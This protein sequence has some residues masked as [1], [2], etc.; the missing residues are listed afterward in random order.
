M[1]NIMNVKTIVMTT[2]LSAVLLAGCEN[3]GKKETKA[4]TG[5][6]EKTTTV[7][8]AADDNASAE[9][10]ATEKETQEAKS[11]NDKKEEKSD[12]QNKGSESETF[13]ITEDN[14]LGAWEYKVGSEYTGMILEEGQLARFL[15]T[16]GTTME[17][18]WN[19][20]DGILKVRLRGGMESFNL[21]QDKLIATDGSREYLKV[22][23][24][25]NIEKT[26]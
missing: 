15:F 7:S 26:N 11:D 20:E 18:R 16:D 2:L 4:T 1:R 9:E 10:K 5:N 12:D 6:Q 24:L 19:I 17:G 23:K 8:V 3:S 13:E 21:G 22:E 14:I 25:A